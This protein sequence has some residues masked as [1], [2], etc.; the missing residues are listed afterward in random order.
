MLQNNPRSEREEEAL[1]PVVH[2][3][4][5]EILKASDVRAEQL[6]EV[7][8]RIDQTS[9]LLFPEF[10]NAL[11]RY[12]VNLED[13]PKDPSIVGI[14]ANANDLSLFEDDYFDL[15]LSNATLE[16]DKYFWLTIAE[17]R[18]VLRPGGMMLVGV[19]G[20]VKQTMKSAEAAIPVLNH[21][22]KRDF[23][24]FSGQARRDVISE[25]LEQITISVVLT[26]PRIIGTGRMPAGSLSRR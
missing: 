13:L 16:H 4:I 23:Y 19:P 18:R 15:V 22:N 6:L 1:H 9:L 26:P 2:G 17:M 21:H 20:Y 8:G 11:E 14:T 24:R 25:G 7:G 5:R 3:K 10:D 12:C